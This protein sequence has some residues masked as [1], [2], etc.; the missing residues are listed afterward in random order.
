MNA[1]L[2]E[3]GVQADRELYSGLLVDAT[4]RL[5]TIVANDAGG[6]GIEEV[7]TRELE[8]MA[9]LH[10]DSPAGSMPCRETTLTY[11]VNPPAGFLSGH[12]TRPVVSFVATAS[13]PP[14]LCTGDSGA[15]TADRARRVEGSSAHRPRPGQSLSRTTGD[16][17]STVKRTISNM[18]LRNY[19]DAV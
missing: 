8:C 3:E 2:V 11:V 9:R 19:Q 17:A 5:S 12:V 7:A 18:H 14:G 15:F 4:A 13:A 1:A 6:V 10:M 16:F